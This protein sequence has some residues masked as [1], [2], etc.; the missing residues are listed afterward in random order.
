MVRRDF[1]AT[2]GGGRACRRSPWPPVV[3]AASPKDSAFG[4]IWVAGLEAAAFLSP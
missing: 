1:S 2:G 4:A 3:A